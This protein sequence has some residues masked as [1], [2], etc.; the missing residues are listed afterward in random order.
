MKSIGDN[1]SALKE[2]GDSMMQHMDCDEF[3]RQFMRIFKTPESTITIALNNGNASLLASSFYDAAIMVRPDVAIGN[4]VYFRFL[5]SD[6][7]VRSNLTEVI[8]LSEFKR[9]KSKFQLAI[10]CGPSLLAVYNVKTQST[11]SIV[12]SDLAENYSTFLPITGQ[13]AVVIDANT[14]ADV[15]A[16]QQITRLLDTLARN[17]HI[18]QDHTHSINEFIRRVLFCLFAEDTQIFA[19]QQFTNAFALFVDNHGNGAES[20]FTDLFTVLNTPESERKN[21]GRPLPKE[22]LAF[23]YVNGGLFADT[24]DIPQ[25]N[26]GTR[27]QLLDCGSLKWNEISPAIFGAM[28][29]NALD[30][31][32]R[33]QLGAHY[34][35]EENILKVIKPLF[36]DAL[37]AEFE[38]LAALDESTP[39]AKAAKKEQLSQFHDKLASLNFLDPACGC[40]NFLLIAY[41]EL[42]R[43]EN[44]VLEQLLDENYLLLEEAIKVN[45]NQFYGIEI[46]D[47]PAEI[48]HLS[49][50]LMQHVMNQETGAKFGVPVAT[51]PLKTSA[52]ICQKN[53]LTTDWNKVL[54]A[55]Q[56]AYIMGNPPFCG[57]TYTTAEQKQWLRDVYPPKHK[58][59]LIDFVSAWFVK[60]ADYMKGNP[61]VQ[62]AF[63]ATNS[64]CQ[65]SQVETLWSLLLSQGIRINFA[66]NSFKWSNAAS[67]NAGVTCTIVG[68][69]YR[70]IFDDTGFKRLFHV[71]SD[72]SLT[73]HHTKAISPYLLPVNGSFDYSAVIVARSAKP[74]A[75]PAC[76]PA[77][78]PGWQS[79]HRP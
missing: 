22:L 64:I 69:A 36:L 61:Q 41:R 14:A 65:G 38:H 72:N 76:L 1:L 33:H 71:S 17:N 10:C 58:V 79:H 75:E 5:K 77:C 49:M 74:F 28:F 20:F 15:K 44:K 53:A 70:D 35:S 42:R 23:P 63:V 78:L 7:D 50:W 3:F 62:A 68:F 51:L 11:D 66:Y 24:I 54:P 73:V 34:T 45:I 59:G 16:C 56:C 32:L 2:L 9:P 25:F 39:K 19:P 48:A 21:I 27:N 30:A 67:K 26:L 52:V 8:S 37:N 29:Q 12:L 4:R 55:G 40:G 18:E 13:Q 43:L 31:D 57:S 60:A 6:D 46:E 47:W